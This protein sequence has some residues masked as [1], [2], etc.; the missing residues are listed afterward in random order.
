MRHLH[1]HVRFCYQQTS[2]SVRSFSHVKRP[3]INEQAYWRRRRVVAVACVTASNIVDVVKR[4]ALTRI[5]H[6]PLSAVARRIIWR[7]FASR[8]H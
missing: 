4:R 6:I 3:L 2:T 7:C 5:K 1:R 8:E